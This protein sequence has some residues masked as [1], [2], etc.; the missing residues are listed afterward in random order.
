MVCRVEVRLDVPAWEVATAEVPLVGLAF[1]PPSAIVPIARNRAN[2]PRTTAAIVNAFSLPRLVPLPGGD[3]RGG[4]VGSLGA[5]RLALAA[6]LLLLLRRAVCKTGV[7]FLA[8]WWWSVWLVLIW[9]IREL[10]L[11]NRRLTLVWRLDLPLPVRIPRWP[12]AHDAL[13]RGSI[14][15]RTVQDT[16]CRH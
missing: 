4:S 11:L 7:G 5:R 3:W 6:G 12:L 16:D 1:P 2:V 9:L 15:A 10:L 14:T 8:N 13:P